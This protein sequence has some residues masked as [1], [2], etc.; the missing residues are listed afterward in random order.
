MP[1]R[2][3]GQCGICKVPTLF[4][5]SHWFH[6]ITLCANTMGFQS[7]D[8]H[9]NKHGGSFVLFLPVVAPNHELTAPLPCD[10]CC[11]QNPKPKSA[12]TPLLVQPLKHSPS[13]PGPC[14]FQHET[15]LYRRPSRR[16]RRHPLPPLTEVNHLGLVPSYALLIPNP[17]VYHDEVDGPYCRH[18]DKEQMEETAFC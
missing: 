7:R 10:I 15:G 11:H 5:W 4:P 9:I 1:I 12:P 13:R 8:K 17:L 6:H 18:N 2:N 14:P 16:C 3:L